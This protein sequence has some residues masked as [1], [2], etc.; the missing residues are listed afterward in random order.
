VSETVRLIVQAHRAGVTLTARADGKLGWKAA[1]RPPDALIAVLERHKADILALL[2]PPR[3]ELAKLMIWR[4]R[5]LGFRPYL[6]DKGVLLIADAHA[7][8]K[9]RRDVGRAPR[10][11]VSLPAR[12]NLPSGAARRL[13]DSLGRF[14]AP[15]GG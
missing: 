10:T 4:L 6:N 13:A 15:W 7:T 14:G 12:R 9:K 3:S 2:P 5:S 11:A 8:G 1:Q